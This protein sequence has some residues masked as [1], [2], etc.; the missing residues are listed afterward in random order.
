MSEEK[1]GKANAVKK[2]LSVAKGDYIVFHDADLEYDPK[3]IPQIVKALEDYDFVIGCRICRPYA[4]GTGPFIANKI[5][6]RLIQKRYSV[7]ISDIFTAQRGFRKGVIVSLPLA[8]GN[9]EMETELTIRAL[10][11]GY[12][13]KEIDVT[14]SPRSRGEGKKIDVSDFFSIIFSYF[15]VSRG[16]SRKTFGKAVLAPIHFLFIRYLT[17]ML[18]FIGTSHI[19]ILKWWGR[20]WRRE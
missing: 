15:S 16:L 18:I 13:F 7:T 11:E 5:L 14:Y 8:S 10:D 12:S 6:L 19:I 3:F 2:G 4:I 9:F 20:K 1:K 17:K